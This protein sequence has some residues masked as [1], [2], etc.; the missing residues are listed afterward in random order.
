MMHGMPTWEALQDTPMLMAKLDVLVGRD[1]VVV[2]RVELD[3]KTTDIHNHNKDLKDI[4][5]YYTDDP[6]KRIGTVT[7]TW[8]DSRTPW[9]TT[10]RLAPFME[11]NKAIGVMEVRNAFTPNIETEKYINGS[12]SFGSDLDVPLVA[13]QI[14]NDHFGS[15]T[16]A[17]VTE[18]LSVTEVLIGFGCAHTSAQE[19]YRDSSSSDQ[20]TDDDDDDDDDDDARKSGKSAKRSGSG[21]AADKDNNKGKNAGDLFSDDDKDEDTEEQDYD[22]KLFGTPLELCNPLPLG[23]P[24]EDTLKYAN[25]DKLTVTNARVV[26][27]YDTR[28]RGK[29]YYRLEGLPKGID[30][31]AFTAVATF[32]PLCASQECVKPYMYDML[33]AYSLKFSPFSTSTPR[34]VITLVTGMHVPSSLSRFHVSGL[35]VVVAKTP[36]DIHEFSDFVLPLGVSGVAKG[37]T[38]TGELS[39]AAKDNVPNPAGPNIQGDT[40]LAALVRQFLKDTSTP[41]HVQGPVT[42]TATTLTAY[43]VNDLTLSPGVLMTD[44]SFTLDVQFCAENTLGL[45]VSGRPEDCAGENHITGFFKGDILLPIGKIE[46]LNLA[47][48]LNLPMG[49]GAKLLADAFDKIHPGNEAAGAQSKSGEAGDG[50]EV[51]TPP[52]AHGQIDENNGHYAY[53]AMYLE[54]S[55]QNTIY[56]AYGIAN[57][58]LSYGV[59]REIMF[60]GPIAWYAMDG[61]LSLGASCSPE[62]IDIP[63]ACVKGTVLAA[64]DPQTPTEN[65]YAG[66]LPASFSLGDLVGF[67]GASCK[68]MWDINTVTNAHFTNNYYYGPYH[69]G[70]DSFSN[71][72]ERIAFPN[73]VAISYGI[74]RHAFT[75]LPRSFPVSAT[76]HAIPLGFT[77]QGT[78]FFAGVYVWSTWVSSALRAKLYLDGILPRIQTGHMT[79]ARAPGVYNVPGYRDPGTH[80]DGAALCVRTTA[81]IGMRAWLIGHVNLWGLGQY[82][83]QRVGDDLRFAGR[84]GGTQGVLASVSIR[85]PWYDLTTEVV[86]PALLKQIENLKKKKNATVA[87][88]ATEG[89]AATKNGN[90]TTATQ[91]QQTDDKADKTA[92]EKERNDD[93]IMNTRI[94]VNAWT[95]VGSLTSE[96]IAE[97]RTRLQKYVPNACRSALGPSCNADVEASSL[98]RVTL[99]AVDFRGNVGDDPS[100]LRGEAYLH[101]YHDDGRHAIYVVPINVSVVDGMYVCFVCVCVCCMSYMYAYRHA[102]MMMMMMMMIGMRCILCL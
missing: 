18:E 92:A 31:C 66:I 53:T 36:I 21:G 95:L 43:S 9:G 69:K 26:S 6:T 54:A 88:N 4:Q 34:G 3:K 94:D 24:I 75:A 1:D 57:M 87:V 79:I 40:H 17:V 62:N 32:V 23:V 71:I 8:A 27:T 16:G 68:N 49:V 76:Y 97:V 93:K 52:A 90:A 101:R 58:H 35:T 39:F 60:G 56:G 84:F 86:T 46:Y 99:C 64:F 100:E 14:E 20:G 48:K 29:A 37:V 28:G 2:P 70:A 61:V 59:V 91:Q 83:V 98:T 77:G 67:V 63:Q 5:D 7:M 82:F 51:F 47:G 89:D 85:T 96:G 50:G 72:C 81:K 12:I 30:E 74:K 73:G 22:D 19:P 102:Y 25:F 13:H 55:V 11:L 42:P 41:L 44:V 45:P 15:L 80:A 33:F 65:L 10:T 38:L 78:L